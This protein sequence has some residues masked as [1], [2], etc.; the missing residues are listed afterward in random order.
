MPVACGGVV[1]RPGDIVVADANGVV[2]VPHEA[3]EW[4]L[5][6]VADLRRSTR[7]SSRCSNAAKVTNIAAISEGLREQGFAVDGRGGPG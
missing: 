2:A 7:R 6:Q 3:T 1:V 4:V 5:R